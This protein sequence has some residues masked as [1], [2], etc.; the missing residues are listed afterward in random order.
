[1]KKSRLIFIF[2]LGSLL[3]SSIIHNSSARSSTGVEVK[4]GESY[5]WAIKL[6][7]S[8]Y[9]DLMMD[10]GDGTI[11]TELVALNLQGNDNSLKRKT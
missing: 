4:K 8:N 11:P 1:M 2:I 10:S 6:N 7:I 3:F 5:N 9:I